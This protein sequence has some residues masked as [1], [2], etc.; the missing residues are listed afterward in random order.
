MVSA[1]HKKELMNAAANLV[2][3]EEG[4]KRYSRPKDWSLLQEGVPI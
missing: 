3:I 4:I 1:V 2:Q